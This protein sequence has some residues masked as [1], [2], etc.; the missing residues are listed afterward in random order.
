MS[1]TS[2]EVGRKPRVAVTYHLY[3][4]SEPLVDMVYVQLSDSW[5]CNGCCTREEDC[6]SRASMVYNS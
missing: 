3:G 6:R 1:Q 5:A 4:E 2:T